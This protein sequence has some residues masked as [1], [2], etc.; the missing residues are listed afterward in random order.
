MIVWYAFFNSSGAV[1]L[2]Q[3]PP[4]EITFPA[5]VDALAHLPQLVL[6][7]DKKR[8]HFLRKRNHYNAAF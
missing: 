5:L 2:H 1:W 7:F 8:L 6:I 4:K 3:P